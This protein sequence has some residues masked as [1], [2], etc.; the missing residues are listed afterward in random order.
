MAVIDAL[1]AADPAAFA[2]KTPP[3]EYEHEKVPVDVI[4]GSPAFR[5]AIDAGER[6]EQI[7][8]RWE[9]TLAAFAALRQPYLLYESESRSR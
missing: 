3:Y 5:H 8:G 7:A 1:R 6:A 9:P 2:W 4:A